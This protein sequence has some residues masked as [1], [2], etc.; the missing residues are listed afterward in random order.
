MRADTTLAAARARLAVLVGLALAL[1]ACA[2]GAT[3]SSPSPL[4]TPTAP[5]AAHPYAPLADLQR[6]P[7]AALVMPGADELARGGEE[8]R[9][10]LGRPKAAGVGVAFGTQ[11]SAEDVFAYYDR[12]LRALGYT[13]IPNGVVPATTE[14]EA[15]G[16]CKPAAAF[17]VGIKN[18]AKAFEPSFL[19]GRS[20]RT[21]FSADLTG[22]IA[23]QP[24]PTP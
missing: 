16:W 22:R 6:E 7:A 18:Q 9:Q 8:R 14:F 11:A 24:C 19:Q 2:V 10:V 15:W 17:R 3:A 1:A 20:Y 4:P 23:S 13:F 5:A 21:V 12:E